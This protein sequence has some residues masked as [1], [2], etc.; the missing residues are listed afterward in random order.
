[1]GFKNQYAKPFCQKPMKTAI[2]KHSIDSLNTQTLLV[3]G[4]KEES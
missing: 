4:S 2:E 3:L 1:M